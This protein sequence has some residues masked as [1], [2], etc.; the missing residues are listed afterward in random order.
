MVLGSYGCQ[1][2]H[3]P[4]GPRAS[5]RLPGEVVE[6]YGRGALLEGLFEPPIEPWSA[7][8]LLERPERGPLANCVG[9][10]QGRAGLSLDSLFS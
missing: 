8:P 1:S 3:R 4:C 5:A 9:S 7:R 6:L 2:S 10:P